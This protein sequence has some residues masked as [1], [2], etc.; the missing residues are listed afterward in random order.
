MLAKYFFTENVSQNCCSLK[1]EL[2]KYL[3]SIS[4]VWL[5]TLYW[6]R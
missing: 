4:Y 5:L 2:A 3:Q 6:C 1:S